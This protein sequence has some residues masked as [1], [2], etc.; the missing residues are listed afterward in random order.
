MD[1]ANYVTASYYQFGSLFIDPTAIY[2]GS[3]LTGVWVDNGSTATLQQCIDRLGAASALAGAGDGPAD[4]HDQQQF[5]T[6]GQLL[7]P[8]VRDAECVDGA[9]RTP[10][11]AS[12]DVTASYTSFGANATS[13]GFYDGTTPPSGWM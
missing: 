1:S 8:V 9:G 6:D 2:D 3:P 11:D 10:M 13:A 5:D 4:L 7:R 12:N